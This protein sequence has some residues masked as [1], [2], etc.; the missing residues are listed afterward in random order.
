MN[1]SQCGSGTPTKLD[2]RK[3]GRRRF[4]SS[5]RAI[6]LVARLGSG[7]DLAM[8]IEDIPPE[9]SSQVDWKAGPETVLGEVD[10]LLGPYNAEIVQAPV[11][12]DA[13]RFMVVA[14]DPTK[15]RPTE[16]KPLDVS[17]VHT[18]PTLTLRR[19]EPEPI[20]TRHD[21]REAVGLAVGEASMCWNPRPAGV[22]DSTHALDVGD[23]LIARIETA[24][25]LPDTIVVVDQEKRPDLHTPNTIRYSK[26]SV[27]NRRQWD[28]YRGGVYSTLGIARESTNGEREGSD[29]VVYR[30]EKGELRVRDAREFL[31]GRFVPRPL[32][33]SNINL[34]YT[35][36]YRDFVIPDE[37]VET[38][39]RVLRTIRAA[40]L[41]PGVT[42]LNKD[43]EGAVLLSHA[44]TWIVESVKEIEAGEKIIG[45]V[46]AADPLGWV[47]QSAKEIKPSDGKS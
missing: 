21:L 32:G 6:G 18:D 37:D 23:R 16:H 25:V 28:H 26:L 20:H 29:V 17:P 41:E 11:D 7:D 12:T 2:A 4:D 1:A 24:V 14:R 38:T 9:I 35:D 19:A 45:Q 8:K 30:N 33:Q 22:F 34:E 42:D 44:H 47:D 40:C 46:K 13:V 39:L 5:S 10:K 31:D 3:N 36:T 15:N 43:A 27:M